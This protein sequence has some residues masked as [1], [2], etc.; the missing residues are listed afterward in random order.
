MMVTTILFALKNDFTYSLGF[1]AAIPTIPNMYNLT[2]M[3]KEY[4][5]NESWKLCKNWLLSLYPIFG[6]FKLILSFKVSNTKMPY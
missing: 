6:A 1:L 3:K 4:K 2:G 5:G